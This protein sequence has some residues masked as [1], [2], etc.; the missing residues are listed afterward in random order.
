MS[1]LTIRVVPDPVLR[2]DCPPVESFDEELGRLADDMV[3]TMHRAPGVG[4]AAPQVG[5][6]K[7]L[8]VVDPTA[9]EDPEAVHVLV[10][11]EIREREGTDLDVEG[12][13]S[14]PGFSEKVPRPV[15]IEL[16]YRDVQG[17]LHEMEA[18]GFPARV[19]CHEV[20]HLHGVLFV[21]HLRGLRRERA[22]RHLRRLAR[23][24][25]ELAR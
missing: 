11:P 25:K 3:E 15:H 24:A 22:Q 12:C 20:D 13:L 8:C 17:G 23:E 18:E 16:T 19:I 5:V 9:G 14:I 2:V 1:V 4:L 21:D 10:N 7:R 6:E